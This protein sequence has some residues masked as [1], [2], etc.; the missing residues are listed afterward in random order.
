MR[1]IWQTASPVAPIGCAR[2]RAYDQHRRA[3]TTA[4]V[5][6]NRSHPPDAILREIYVRTG[7]RPFVAIDEVISASELAQISNSYKSISGYGTGAPMAN[8]GAKA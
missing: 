1:A 4:V 5:L 6:A 3:A 8:V 7:D 2:L